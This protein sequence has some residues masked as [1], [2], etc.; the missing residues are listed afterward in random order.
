[1]LPYRTDDRPSVIKTLS[2]SS[3]FLWIFC[4]NIESIVSQFIF[5]DLV[6]STRCLYLSINLYKYE[7]LINLCLKM[8]LMKCSIVIFSTKFTMFPSCLIKFHDKSILC[9]AF[10]FKSKDMYMDIFYFSSMDQSNNF[11]VCSQE[12]SSEEEIF[13]ISDIERMQPL[14]KRYLY[15]YLCN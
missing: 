12:S 13:D 15:L 3:H 14:K 6:S 8:S 1:M 9:C 2:I 11:S 7:N 4:K 10:F 5:W